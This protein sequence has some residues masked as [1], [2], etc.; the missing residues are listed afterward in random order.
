MFGLGQAIA[1]HET[2]IVAVAAAY[3][4]GLRERTAC[5]PILADMPA[6]PDGAP[7]AAA[8]RRA[9]AGNLLSVKEQEAMHP[10]HAAI[11]GALRSRIGR[12]R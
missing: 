2:A 10:V 8:L 7:L 5:E 11:I 9:A 1:D 3:S 12:Q 4:G 6:E